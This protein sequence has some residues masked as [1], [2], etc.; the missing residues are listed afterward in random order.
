MALGVKSRFA[1]GHYRLGGSTVDAQAESLLDLVDRVR[2]DVF[3]PIG[4]R[5]TRAAAHCRDRLGAMT[6]TN[7][8]DVK[9][10]GVADDKAASMKS[11]EALGI[12]CARVFTREA[13]AAAF[14]EGSSSRFV[15]KPNANIGSAL[16]VFYVGNQLE[17]DDAIDACESRFG[18]AVI[19]EYVPG[20]STAMKTALLLY[21]KQGRLITSFTTQKKRQWPPSGGLTVSSTSTDDDSIV[22]QVAPFFERWRWSGAAEVELKRDSVTGVDKVIEINPRFPAYLRFADRCGLDLASV[23]ARAA[24]DAN[25]APL[26]YPAYRVGVHYMNPGLMIKSAALH[27]RSF[28][29]PELPGIIGECGAGLHCAVDMLRDPLPLFARYLG[30][31]R[32]FSHRSDGS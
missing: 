9:A 6:A 29:G 4:M 3:L 2:P 24:L 15:V 23:A 10:F 14:A 22:R 1:K 32:S 5:A 26:D 25:I 30:G 7:V 11:L 18:K 17:L 8:P 21:S 28:R 13:A 27:F 31:L 20:D 16:G 12:A 19:Q